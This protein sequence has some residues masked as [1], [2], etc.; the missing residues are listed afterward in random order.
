[1][2]DVRSSISQAVSDSVKFTNSEVN[3]FPQEMYIR[4]LNY[5]FSSLESTGAVDSAAMTAVTSYRYWRDC[6]S[7]VPLVD[8]VDTPAGATD[9]T[10]QERLSN[11]LSSGRTRRD[12]K[13]EYMREMEKAQV[14]F[15]KYLEQG[16]PRN[17]NYQTVLMEMCQ[18]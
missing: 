13:D 1:M 11:L 12:K 6:Q 15:K 2:K 9:V 8:A 3:T 10:I 18:I 5:E 14:A 16:A 7:A 17:S 4:D